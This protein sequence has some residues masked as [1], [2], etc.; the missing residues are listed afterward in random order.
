MDASRAEQRAI[1]RFLM[2]DGE[3]NADS[4][5]QMVV[6]EKIWNAD[7]SNIDISDFENDKNDDDVKDPAFAPLDLQNDS[8]SE[9]ET[10]EEVSIVPEIS[11][12]DSVLEQ[13]N[14]FE[15]KSSFAIRLFQDETKFAYS[16]YSSTS[17]KNPTQTAWLQIK[18][19]KNE[20][21]NL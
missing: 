10:N 12:V 21:R 13:K 19:R 9:K 15:C 5:H 7:E 6:F 18:L 14:I 1:S 8:S 16:G 2:A 4:Y 3:R 11:I 20:V 17:I